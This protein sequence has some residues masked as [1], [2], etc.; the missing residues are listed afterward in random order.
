MSRICLCLFILR[1]LRN[2]LHSWEKL[3]LVVLSYFDPL[4]RVS[5]DI[6]N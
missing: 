5:K 6:F 3:C 2:G 4:P 1:L